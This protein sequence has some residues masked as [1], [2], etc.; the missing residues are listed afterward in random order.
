MFRLRFV[1]LLMTSFEA[2]PGTPTPG[3]RSFPAKR[4]PK[5]ELRHEGL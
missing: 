3:K 5:P 2:Y 4:V 1:P